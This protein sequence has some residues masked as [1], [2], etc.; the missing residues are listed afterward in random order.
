MS[1]C[2]GLLSP[3]RELLT[4][5]VQV[6]NGRKS[7]NPLEPSPVFWAISFEASFCFYGVFWQVAIITSCYCLLT[8][9]KCWFL[10][11]HSLTR[12]N[13]HNFISVKCMLWGKVPTSV[14]GLPSWIYW[15]FRNTVS[16]HA[17]SDLV[18]ISCLFHQHKHKRYRR[19]R[20][21]FKMDVN[22]CL[23]WHW[24]KKICVSSVA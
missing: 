3:H 20:K 4:P 22:I 12:M 6:H 18:C 21:H 23:F 8:E 10:L 13:D 9:G 17:V 16:G 11:F 7:L 19:L 24:N 14:W 5:L 1:E 15:M 2:A